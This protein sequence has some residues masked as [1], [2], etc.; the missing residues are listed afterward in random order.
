MGRDHF[1][2]TCKGVCVLEFYPTFN[3]AWGEDRHIINDVYGLVCS[4]CGE[5]S[6]TPEQVYDIE[7]KLKVKL[8]EEELADGTDSNA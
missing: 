8:R 5:R 2:F 7:A 1:C 6:F 4:E 3:T